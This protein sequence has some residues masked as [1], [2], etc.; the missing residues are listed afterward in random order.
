MLVA[1]N[2]M[3]LESWEKLHRIALGMYQLFGGKEKI[4]S[5]ILL[6]YLFL[7]PICVEDYGLRISFLLSLTFLKV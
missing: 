6:V 1:A 5:N 4:L 7:K 3:T 2:P